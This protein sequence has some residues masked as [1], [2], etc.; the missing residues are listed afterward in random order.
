MAGAVGAGGGLMSNFKPDPTN[1]KEC[2]T[3]APENP[4]GPCAGLP[5]YI[6]CKYSDGTRVYACVCDWIHWIC[7]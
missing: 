7:I 5:I 1:P 3:A 6:N 4:W 2:P